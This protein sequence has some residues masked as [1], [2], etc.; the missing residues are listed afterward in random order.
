[1]DISG[2]KLTFYER[3]ILLI[4]KLKKKYNKAIEK[5]KTRYSLL[6]IPHSQES[7][8]K[9][10]LSVN[11]MIF[12]FTIIVS[13]LMG[14]VFYS[15]KYFFFRKDYSQLMVNSKKNHIHFLYYNQASKKLKKQI[16]QLTVRTEELHKAIWGKYLNKQYFFF[17][18]SVI[19]VNTLL[20][21][22]D[23]S[24][25]NMKIYPETVKIYSHFNED[26]SNLRTN[27]TA[28]IEYIDNREAIYQSMP[29]G[30][31]LAPGVGF[32]SSLF[33]FRSDPFAMGG[34]G[35]YHAGIDFA[36]PYNTPLYATGPGIVVDLGDTSGGL[37]RSI[38]IHHG[39]GIYSVYAHCAL[40]KV[41]KGQK[42]S[43]GELIGLVGA[44]GKAT[45]SHVHYEVHIGTDPPIDPKEFINFE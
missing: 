7:I 29:Q 23:D 26:L 18:A 12:L 16:E 13:L 34:K 45:G 35:D 2:S 40:Q 11:L 4:H 39:Y 44:T 31:P 19:D 22:P 10:E 14:S 41:V 33:G 15:A 42:V 8:V 9:I 43:R 5:G 30:R 32:T 24:K 25:S 17:D 3:S 28:A 20:Q 36:A 6:F 37:G 1:M 27:F 38:K 21:K